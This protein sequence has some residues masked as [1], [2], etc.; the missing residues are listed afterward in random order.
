MYKKY[1]VEKQRPNQWW[2]IILAILI[3]AIWL[4]GVVQQIFI[5]KAFGNQP[6]SDTAL[7]LMGLIAFLPL[8]LLLL[9]NLETEVR[10][11]GVYYKMSPFFRYKKIE[12]GEI[13]SW[14]IRNYQPIKEYGG[15]GNRFSLQRKKSK[16]YNVKGKTG[17]QIELQS[18]KRILI[19]TQRPDD[20][21]QAME[22]LVPEKLLSY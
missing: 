16:A 14:H 20:L 12:K 8:F 18:G 10:R 22:Q 15:W 1:F 9:A 17:L 21:H 6:V 19:G 4:W 11:D 2:L 7:L 5:G 3:I 13:K